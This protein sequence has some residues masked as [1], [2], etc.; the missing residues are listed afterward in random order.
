MT[1]SKGGTVSHVVQTGFLMLQAPDGTAI[2]LQLI[3]SDTAATS[4]YDTAVKSL[5]HFEGVV[6]RNAIIFLAPLG[7]GTVPAA[8]VAALRGLLR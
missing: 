3:D 2:D 6:D 1:A 7:K 4:E 8:D 5:D